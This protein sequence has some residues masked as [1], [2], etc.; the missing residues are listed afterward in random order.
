M[1]EKTT[2]PDQTKNVAEENAA[3]DDRRIAPRKRTE[4]LSSIVVD[5][6]GRKITCMVH[7]I[8]K[9]G[10]MIQTSLRELPR[11]FILDNP[12]EG[13]R[14]ACRV[15]WSEGD[16]TGIEFVKTDSN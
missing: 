9:T 7:N 16:L 2:D 6:D 14:R 5:I 4:D 8:S 13:I 3:D 10:A 12:K 1:N 11:R 15:I